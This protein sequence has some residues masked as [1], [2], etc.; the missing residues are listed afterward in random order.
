MKYGLHGVNLN[1]C[2][3]PA[4]ATRLGRAAGFDLLWVADHAVLA[5]QLTSLDVRSSGR[6]QGLNPR[7]E[8]RT[9]G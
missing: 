2:G 5:K 7:A 3:S 6:P 4:S 1:T 9:P 8:E